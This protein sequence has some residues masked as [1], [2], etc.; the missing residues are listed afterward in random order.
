MINNKAIGRKLKELRNSRDLKQ[1]ELA[2]LVGLSRPYMSYMHIL[3]NEFYAGSYR[4]N[5]NYAEPY[6]TKETY[7]SVQTALQSN[8]RT[9]MQRHVYLFTG[10]LRCPECRSKLVGVSHP[11]GG[12][13]Y[14]YYRCNNAHSVHTCTHKK[15]YA[16][17]ATEK[18]LLSNLDNL[19][20]DHIATIS[21][22]TSE[23]KDTTEK[24]LKELR[25]EL[26]NLNY[27][28]IKKRMPVSTYERL[29]AET[30]DKIKRLESF[31]P[32]STDHLQQFLNSGWRSIYDN[33]TRENKRTLWRNI[34]DSVHV[35]PDKIEVFFK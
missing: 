27:I 22:I 16:E 34:L 1:S 33:L 4:G 20:K 29:Y 11:K 8:I 32:K 25:K 28:F 13:R 15:H 26:D 23:A 17:L 19:L 2:E 12:K 24:E 35:S 6:I 3:K 14:Y 21:S 7:N 31:K 9:G 30:E 18:Y 10:L 5:S